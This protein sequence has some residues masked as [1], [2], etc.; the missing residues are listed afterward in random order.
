MESFYPE[1]RLNAKRTYGADG[2]LTN[3]RASNTA[4]LLHWGKWPGIFWTA[5]CGWLVRP[6]H[7]HYLYTGDRQFLEKR[8]VPFLEQVAGGFIRSHASPQLR[9]LLFKVGEPI[10]QPF[11]FANELL[12]ELRPL[13]KMAQQPVTLLGEI[14]KQRI[15]RGRR[16]PFL[17]LHHGTDWSRNLSVS[18]ERY[19]AHREATKSVGNNRPI[20]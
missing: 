10:E 18:Q 5:G 17:I 16:W 6:F 12:G 13:R 7:E 19:H 1:W 14:R 3:A 15:G 4:L 8:T 20:R 11:V 9:V 2:L